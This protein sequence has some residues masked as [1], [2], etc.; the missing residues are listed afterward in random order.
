MAKKAWIVLNTPQDHKEDAKRQP[1]ARL[2]KPW[3][4]KKNLL[5]KINSRR[6]FQLSLYEL[7]Y[8]E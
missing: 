7:P 5:M 2:V 1:M 4:L 3:K 6:H 8:A